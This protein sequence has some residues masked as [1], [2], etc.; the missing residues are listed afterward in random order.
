MNTLLIWLASFMLKKGVRSLGLVFAIMTAVSLST[1][2]LPAHAEEE[3]GNDH[4]AAPPISTITSPLAD[5]KIGGVTTYTITGTASSTG[6]SVL[7][8]K[9]STD[10]G[11]SWDL[12]TDTSGNESWASWSFTWEI[13]SSKNNNN[14]V[15]D[16]SYVI[17]SRAK[18][19]GDS[20][21]VETAG[22]GVTVTV[23]KTKPDTTA[24][25]SG[26]AFGSLTV[27]SPISVTLSAS[28]GAGSGVADGSPKYC[29]DSADTC[30]P[31]L[32]YSAAINVI[33][34]PGSI[35]TQYVRYQSFDNA[36]NSEVVKS[37]IVKQNPPDLQPPTTSASAAGYA[38]GTWTGTS[39]VSVLLSANDA[40]SGIASGYP[41]YCIDAANTCAPD[42][43]YT[44]AI[45]IS[46]A[47]GSNCTQ[48]VR[49]QSVD[50][51]GNTETVQSSV[52]KQDLQSP[53]AGV[54]PAG[55]KIGS[56]AAVSLSCDDGAGSGC[57]KIYYTTD[58]ST[59]TA[60]SSAYAGPIVISE[61]TSMNFLAVDNAGNSAAV[62]TAAYITTYRVTAGTGANG[63]ISCTP[64]IVDYNS[65]SVCL[66]IPGAEYHVVDV[67]VGPTKGASTSVG[68][69]ASYSITNI[70]ADM[71]ISAEFARDTFTITPSAGPGGGISPDTAQTIPSNGTAALTVT[72]DTGY[73]IASV[74]GCNGTLTGG[75]YAT[76]PITGNCT[77]EAV[78]AINT[79]TITT[80]AGMNGSVSCTPT[81]VPYNS[82]S[83]CTITADAGYHATVT[84]CNGTLTGHTYAISAVQSDCTIFATFTNSAPSLPTIVSPLSETETTTLT[85]ALAVSAAT[86]PDGDAVMY[87]FEIYSDGGLST[88]V[89]GTT[90]ESTNWTTPAL[91]DNTRYYW[92]AQAND[93]HM[94]SNWMTTANF[95]VNT[96]ND[97]PS[98]PGISAP[99]NNVH[100]STLTPAL[101]VTNAADVDYYDTL[102]YDYE[103]AADGQFT[104]IAARAANVAQ[105]AGGATSWIVTPA[106]SENTPYFWRVRAKDNNGGYSN[107]V[108][109]S[110][111]VN[112]ANDA[113]TAPVLKSPGSGEVQ[114]SAP[115]LVI[116][117]A[118]DADHQALMYTFE[119]DTVETFNSS[120]KQTSG[121]IAEGAGDTGWTPAA[122]T[123]NTTYYWKAKANDGLADGPWMATAEFFVNTVNDAPSVPTLNNPAADAWVTVLAP[124]LQVNAST[125][126]DGDNLTYEYE[127]FSDSGL[128]TRVT[129]A[130]GAGNSWV[131]P[132]NLSDNTR[133]W[134]RAQAKD[135]HGV[136]SGWMAASAFFVNDKGYNDPPAI[137]ITRPGASESTNGTDFLI[138]W[139]ASDPDSDPAITLFY[140]TTGSGHNGTQIA[141]GMHL[142]DPISSYDWNISGLADGAY[143]VYARIDDGNT[144]VYAY[145]AGPLTIV[146]TPPTP[147]ITASAGQNGGISPS[148]AVSVASGASQYFS[149]TPAAG[150]R[151]LD[152]VVD[153]VSQGERDAWG[154]TNVGADHTISVTFTPD[155]YTITATAD[156]NGSISPVGA[157]VVS[158]GGSQTY[159][160]TPNQGYTVSYV[161]VDGVY[162]GPLTSFEFTNVRANHAIMAYFTVI[163]HTITAS[164][165]SHG[166]IS[167]SG[168]VS[169]PNGGS[170]A[171]DITAEAGYHIEA[172]LVDGASVGAVARY[173]FSNVTASH[174]IV[175]TFAPNASKTIT[176]TAGSNGAISPAGAVSVLGGAGQTFTFTP[177]TGY[178]VLDVVVDGASV[179]A[180]TSY[181]FTNVQSNHTINATFTLNVYTITATAGG[182]GS[183]TPSGLTTVQPG[184]S[185]AYSIEPA[186]GYEVENVVIDG[187]SKGAITT[188]AFSSI[189][190]DHTISASFRVFGYTITASAGSHGD[191]S[192]SGSVFV[193]EGFNQTF[194]ITPA[195]GYHL[196]AVLVDG[197][198]VGAVTTYDFTSVAAAH[199]IS[200]TFEQNAPS[201]ITA[202]A[203]QNG[204][205]SPSGAVSVASG[206]SQYFFFTPAA[207]YRVLDVV[208][209]GVSQ[210]ARDAW[211][212]T[213]VGANHSISVTFTPDVY[214]ITATA[215]SNGSI[216]PAG[217]TVV[218]KGDS[219]TYEI[220]PDQGYSVSYV[221]V[222]QAYKGPITSFTFTNVRTNHVITAYFTVTTHTI[223]ASAGSHG[224]ISPSGNVSVLNGG[225]LLFTITAEAGYHI[226][227][228]LV[229]GASVGAVESYTFTDV[230]A[231]HTISATFAENEAFFITAPDDMDFDGMH[232]SISPAGVLPDGVVRVLGGASQ[233]FTFTPD[234]DYRVLDVVVDGVSMGVVTS[235]TFTNVQTNHTINATFTLN[236]F[237]ITAMAGN[238]G[239]MSLAPATTVQ[240]GES[241]TCTVTP[242]AGFE[243]EN[244]VVDGVSKGAITTYTFSSIAADH[245]ISASFRVYVFG[246][247]ITASA[248]PNGGISPS[249]A[250]SVP[251]GSD[252]L[253][254]ITPATG[255]HVTEVLVDGAS[256]GAVTSYTFTSVAAT[257]TISATFAQ[258]T[259]RTI[260]ASAG[261]N[262]SI[263]PAGVT[264]VSNG[265]SQ[266]YLFTPL[267]EEY[268]LAYVIVDGMNIGAPA[269]Y[270]FSNVSM[271]HVITAYFNV[272]PNWFGE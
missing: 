74:T 211:G 7:K 113:P 60:N 124:T 232:G 207:G 200:A 41:K 3:W 64:T 241:L 32:A 167:P 145:A 175:A 216:S 254:T 99:I 103:V 210:G 142:S 171:F 188:Y 189:A 237:T 215:N 22:P 128:S 155:V 66:I 40:G 272:N 93:G 183:I 98:D 111:F 206:A 146:R 115:M 2:S 19:K 18:S 248:G 203:G 184:G 104:N 193:P 158:K 213:N 97:G 127:V 24:F 96:V 202:S 119:L 95:V 159:E 190:A 168:N 15:K 109:A 27:T 217:A 132:M 35:C 180:K 12:A 80:G 225:S 68:V 226:A 165:G 16:G 192:P 133:Y 90:T 110:F 62:Q 166:G 182:N 106:L 219:Q 235:Y 33:C 126:A 77:V 94:N 227:A 150:Y 264:V 120:N 243:V 28:D 223:T 154:F 101:S 260:T 140:D 75:T 121:L 58:G 39:S 144:A 61:T 71:T 228:V 57:S 9:V 181:T 38:F 51:A 187:V 55:G 138:T 8:V 191:I 269:S 179:G 26:Y 257:H 221:T 209:D 102:T 169:V 10:G 17:L 88:L 173:D 21:C 118:T 69:Y 214:T 70:K 87:T 161:T 53:V 130:T 123:E 117:N 108:I 11:K 73:H 270:T 149:F 79:A 114:A 156:S 63:T 14:I 42:N 34:A 224:G 13:S 229:D 249:G 148:G 164:V 112:T 44:S 233:T 76:G 151:V 239:S 45:D 100:V 43:S 246:Y 141:T 86:D 253:F 116:N 259:S 135:E 83:V 136:A 185:Q 163:T 82:G 222:D 262:G 195:A 178:R 266:T 267:S 196:L 105:V 198:S 29:V 107:F 129:S 131:F 236:V 197:A 78:F 23:D 238:N 205:I 37:S 67:A 251:A 139:T 176:A 172:V 85:P 263:S 48:Y 240:P 153:G 247:M 56:S 208:V 59:P 268:V 258:N 65:S 186:A 47:A 147:V 91:S 199:T 52:V 261:P 250:V 265:G 134:W 174:T 230:M 201:T 234:P 84:G 194:T 143:F 231:G 49:Y 54:S 218:S 36:G 4:C 162:K 271:N 31:N 81:V 30:T 92:R 6:K 152:V 50:N 1:L 89:T 137:S 25:S 220:I 256:V 5:A 160:I 252:Q 157:T 177:E 244:V 122:L 204:G 255:Y 125:D 46:C 212:F 72:P 242:A 170:R 20:G 245:T